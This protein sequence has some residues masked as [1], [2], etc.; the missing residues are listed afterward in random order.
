MEHNPYAAPVHEGPPGGPT[1]IAAGAD[2]T[3]E[4]VF[5]EAWRL[6]NGFKGTAWAAL[7]VVGLI[8]GGAS[9]L[10]GVV[11]V[12]P[13]DYAASGDMLNQYLTSAWQGLVL[14]PLS[15]P[16]YAGIAMLSLRRARGQDASFNSVFGYFTKMLPLVAAGLLTSLITYLGFA[17]LVIP[18]IYLSIALIFAQWLVVDR[19]LGPWEAVT[20]S[21]KGVHRRWFHVFGVLFVAG[22]I[23]GVSAIPLGIGLIWTLPWFLLVEAVL[24]RSIFAEDSNAATPSA[25]G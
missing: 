18:G 7:L 9:A 11:T 6:K 4:Q 20:T 3:L 25:P 22:L 8:T 13:N 15:A 19:N 5:K 1:P 2:L 12:S 14:L 21:L 17:A 24:Y 16:L 23:V 10:L